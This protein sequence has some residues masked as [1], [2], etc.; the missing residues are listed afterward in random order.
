MSFL[1]VGVDPG[2]VGVAHSDGGGGTFFVAF[3]RVG[4]AVATGLDGALCRSS[5]GRFGTDATNCIQ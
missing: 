2:L 1:G 5:I 4:I 3:Y